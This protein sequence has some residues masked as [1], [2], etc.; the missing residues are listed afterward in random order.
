MRKREKLVAARPI[1][2]PP[3][4]IFLLRGNALALAR[5][6]HVS[7]RRLPLAH[8]LSI[9][10][11]LFPSLL[12]AVLGRAIALARPPAPP[13]LSRA[14]THFTAIARS[15][16]SWPEQ[17]FTALEQ[18]TPGPMATALWPLADVPNKMTLVHGRR[19]LP[20]VKSRSEALTSLRGV[21]PSPSLAAFRSWSIYD[22]RQSR[23]QP[24]ALWPGPLRVFV[25]LQERC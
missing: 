22:M 20:T 16:M 13:L 19:L 2:W 21:F 17:P 12:L 18:T 24:L 8:P 14:A 1:A 5:R 15:W 6:I 7:R 23:D 11:R 4:K 10:L 3:R 25:T 9:A